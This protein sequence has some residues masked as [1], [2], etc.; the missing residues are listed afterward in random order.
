MFRARRIHK[1]DK[2][3]KLATMNQQSYYPGFGYEQSFKTG[4]YWQQ[5]EHVAELA[6]RYDPHELPAERVG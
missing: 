1:R 4:P 2:R 5:Q 6:E 3:E